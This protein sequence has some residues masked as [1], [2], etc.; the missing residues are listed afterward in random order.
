MDEKEYQLIEKYLSNELTDTELSDFKSRME[1]DPDFAI[2]VKV[3]DD[4]N[5]SLQSRADSKEQEEKL[6]QTINYVSSDFFSDQKKAGRVVSMKSIYWVAAAS[7]VLLISFIFIINQQSVPTFEEYAHYEPL[8]L[9]NRSDADQTLVTSAEEAFNSGQ[10][11]EAAQRLDQLLASNP[12][13][14]NLK[15]YLALSL[16][17]TGEYSRAEELLKAI[18]GGNSVY[19]PM[20]T[21]YLALNYLKQGRTE[22]SRETLQKISEQSPYYKEAQELLGEL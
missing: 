18:E 16:I 6:K 17:E 22:D 15:L 9:T 8:V 5:S 21:W 13:Q 7:L 12:D 3:Y 11:E 2:T 10:F 20:A 14:P 4:V 19:Q 1:T